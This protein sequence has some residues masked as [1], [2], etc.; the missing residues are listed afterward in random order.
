MPGAHYPGT[1]LWRNGASC[2]A[3]IDSVAEGMLQ[4]LPC[5]VF[6]LRAAA[7][8]PLCESGRGGGEAGCLRCRR[9]LEA[10]HGG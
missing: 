10:G 7:I 8:L 3:L 9:Y 1:S 6:Q 4:G 2:G 5:R